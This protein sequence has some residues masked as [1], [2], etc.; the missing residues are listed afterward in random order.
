MVRSIGAPREG[1]QFV[2]ADFDKRLLLLGVPFSEPSRIEVVNMDDVRAQIIRRFS[3][4]ALDLASWE[5]RRG[6]VKPDQEPASPPVSFLYYLLDVPGLGLSVGVSYSS[7]KGV[8]EWL[9]PLDPRMP[10]R[11]V[12][13][14]QHGTV[15]IGGH[16]GFDSV[17]GYGDGQIVRVKNKKLVVVAAWGAHEA[18]LPIPPVPDFWDVKPAEAV[19]LRVYNKSIVVLQRPFA[20][21]ITSDV[22]NGSTELAILDQSTQK[23]RSYRV[24]GSRMAIRAYGT[25]VAGTAGTLRDAPGSAGKGKKAAANEAPVA[26]AASA[27]SASSGGRVGPRDAAANLRYSQVYYPGI[28]WLIDS[29]KGRYY[30][31]TTSKANS[32]ILYV[33]APT[34][35]FRVENK[36]YK[37]DIQ[38]DTVGPQILL[39]EDEALL[40]T[41]WAFI[42]K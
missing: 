34:I 9:V 14:D 37:A 31:I 13:P 15:R 20:T 25:W 35:Y 7:F 2:L 32:E 41:H 23:W 42:G 1:S 8:L 36:L 40:N 21:D 27:A 29:V 10:T 11:P 38:G 12:A 3:G 18:T 4:P 26:S 24:T 16:F 6:G 28:L 39:A 5:P 17:L 30:E 22:G 19:S 33:D